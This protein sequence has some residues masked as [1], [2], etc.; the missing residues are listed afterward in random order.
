MKIIIKKYVIIIII[1]IIMPQLKT[2]IASTI[3]F[4][5]IN[6]GLLLYAR[7]RR[8]EKNKNKYM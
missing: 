2:L 8:R 6:S 1:L 3:L 4:I 5:S 7:E